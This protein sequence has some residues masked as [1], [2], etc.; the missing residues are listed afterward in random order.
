VDWG[1]AEPGDFVRPPEPVYWPKDRGVYVVRPNVAGWR[2]YR[3]L[4]SANPLLGVTYIT[5]TIQDRILYVGSGDWRRPFTRHH[6]NSRGATDATGYGLS[7]PEESR[8]IEVLAIARSR[9]LA[10]ILESVIC[11]IIHPPLNAV[12]RIL[13]PDRHLSER[14]AAIAFWNRNYASRFKVR[15]PWPYG[16]GESAQVSAPPSP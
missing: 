9:W 1:E 7:T 13:P 10:K 11:E 8:V 2:A 14:D 5:R 6:S 15:A 4:A 12:G 3:E 16:W